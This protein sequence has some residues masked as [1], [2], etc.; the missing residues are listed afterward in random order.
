M[1]EHK[2]QSK[3]GADFLHQ[4]QNFADNHDF[5]TK[6]NSQKS[7]FTMA[8]NKYSHLSWTEF[9]QESRLG[10]TKRPEN[11]VPD[12]VHE[13]PTDMSSVPSSIDWEAKGAVTPVKDQGQCGSC[14]S[15]S[16]TGALEGIYQITYNDLQSF[17]EQELVSCDQS[18]LGDHGCNGGLMDNAFKWVQS[19]GG[20]CSEADYPYT[21]GVTKENGECNSHSS[22]DNTKLKVTSYTDVK[23]DSEDAL[24][25][26]L[27]QQPVSVA[28]Q[29]NQPAF[30]FYSEGVL[31]GE[32]GTSLDH[33]V[34]AVGY[35]T[36]TDGTDYYKVKNSWGDGWGMDGYILIE[37]GNSQRGGECGILMGPPSYPN[38]N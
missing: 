10:L 1:Q 16:A 37:R 32:C 36:Y 19:N 31:T 24:M 12:S 2:M 3:S 27:A 20:L 30:Q 5:I 4:L 38:L 18:F 29:A 6:H 34:L 21:S 17:S 35:G 11:A 8:H 13:A 9:L 26:A 14:W 33:G 15:F 7:T 28:I 23:K 25:S 22:C